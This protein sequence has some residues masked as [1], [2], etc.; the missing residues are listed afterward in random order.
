MTHETRFKITGK[1]SGRDSCRTADFALVVGYSRETEPESRAPP[2]LTN[3][4]DCTTVQLN[5][6]ESGGQADSCTLRFG[7]EIQVKDAV[8]EFARDAAARVGNRDLAVVPDPLGSNRKFAAI[9]HCFQAVVNHVKNSLF[10][11]VWVAIDPE[12]VGDQAFHLNAFG[13]CVDRNQR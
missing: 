8:L 13:L 9:G 3:K 4:I 7:G 2:R 5:H 11:K 10:Q 12:L 1:Y 6:P